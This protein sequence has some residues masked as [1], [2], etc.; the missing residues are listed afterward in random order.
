MLWPRRLPFVLLLLLGT[1]AAAATPQTQPT[2][3]L[4]A[5]FD[6]LLRQTVRDQRVD[7]TAIARDHAPALHGY[8]DELAQVDV[9]ALPRDAQLAYYLNLYNASM[10]QAVLDRRKPGWS[11][12]ADD[13]AV[14]KAK[15]VRLRGRTITLNELENDIIRPTFKDPRIHAALVCGARS[16]PPL[17]ARAYRAEDLDAVLTANV[18]QWIAND[19]QRNRI[20]HAARRLRLSQIFNWFAVDFGGA[21]ALPAYVGKY[22]QRDVS[23]YKV[24]YLDYDWTLNSTD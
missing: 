7:Y 22:L 10:I 3:D 16:C 19:P 11:P 1:L 4:H 8:L 12:A 9:A 13:F 5:G 14:F 15:L 21:A 6:S 17:L 23:G 20:D 18:Q 24:E 2:A